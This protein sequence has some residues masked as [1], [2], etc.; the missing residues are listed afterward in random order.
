MV[1][2]ISWKF[3]D[4]DDL[5]IEIHCIGDQQ[6]AK[7]RCERCFS[8]P[9]KKMGMVSCAKYRAKDTTDGES[10]TSRTILNGR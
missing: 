8:L 10:M 6:S 5:L 4:Y 3:K 7:E 1:Y 9:D 2:K